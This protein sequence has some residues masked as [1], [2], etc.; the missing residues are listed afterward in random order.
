MR[1]WTARISGAL[2]LTLFYRYLRPML[3]AGRVFA[4]VPPLHRIE[5]SGTRKGQPK[6]RYTYPTPSSP[7]PCWSSSAA[8]AA[9]RSRCSGTRASVRWTRPSWPRPPWIRGT[10]PC[11]GSGSR[12]PP[13]RRAC[14]SL[15]MGSDVGPRRDFIVGGAAELDLARID[16]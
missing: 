3:D 4:A 8:G 13:R 6:Y 5:L 2:L 7:A 16:A 15:L 12:P 14:S 10:G 11:A 9:G 1:T